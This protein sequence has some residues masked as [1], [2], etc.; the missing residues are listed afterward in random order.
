MR[1]GNLELIMASLL[2]LFELWSIAFEKELV[3]LEKT[4]FNFCY[5]F[6]LSSPK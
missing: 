1:L 6:L 4:G 5:D 3:A 2:N